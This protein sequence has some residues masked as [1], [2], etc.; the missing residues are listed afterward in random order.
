MS[1]DKHDFSH[2]FPEHK[3]TIH[4]LK[5]NN[6]HFQKLFDEYHQVTHEIHGIEENRVNVS[7]EYFEERKIKRVKLKDELYK[8]I[9][10]AKE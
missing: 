4:Q 10:D 6:K 2:D 8:M 1:I 9:I 3:E 7:D 5:M